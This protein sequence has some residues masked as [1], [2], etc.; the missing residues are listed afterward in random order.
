MGYEQITKELREYIASLVMSDQTEGKLRDLCDDI[1][2]IT[3]RGWVKLP[4]D[5]DGVPIRAGDEV[6][7]HQIN[8]APRGIVR[9]IE[10]TTDG[11]IVFVGNTGRL[12]HCYR[13]YKPDTWES[14]I[15]DAMKLGYTDPDNEHLEQ[16]LVARC[17]ALAGEDE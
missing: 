15:E 5:A 10:L 6:V 8:P 4:V 17:K 16:K 3:E 12:P 14:I 2:A 13:H 9:S 11:W 7:C 1:D